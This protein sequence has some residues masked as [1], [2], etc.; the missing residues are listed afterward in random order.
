LNA[1]SSAS[2]VQQGETVVLSV[3]RRTSGN[4]KQVPV[5]QA[6]GQCWFHV[7]P[8]V[9][10]SQVADSVQW[11]VDPENSVAF[12]AEYRFDH[13]R[14]ATMNV[15]GTIRLTPASEVPCEPDRMVEGPTLEIAVQ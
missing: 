8:P 10:E 1:S 15:K 7:R 12:N 14:I 9:V 5:N 13:A 3:E 11:A 2:I 6:R 4:W